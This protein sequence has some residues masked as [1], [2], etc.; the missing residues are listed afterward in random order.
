[1]AANRKTHSSA[2]RTSEARSRALEAFRVLMLER[3]YRR[4]TIQSVLDRARVG[5]ATFY[6]HFRGKEDLLA[7]SVAGLGRALAQAARARAAAGEAEPLP[8]VRPLF[9]HA[10]RSRGMLSVLAE[11]DTDVLLREHMQRMLAGLVREELS[12][13]SGEENVDETAVQFVVGG[14]WGLMMWWAREPQ[15]TPDEVSDAFQRLA[16]PVLE[17]PATAP[18]RG[19]RIGRR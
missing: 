7:A 15:L 16:T 2:D 1:M 4:V 8:F 18:S 12:S 13:R 14:L 10:G 3:G 11:R 19:R 6:A 17:G 9:H 5:R